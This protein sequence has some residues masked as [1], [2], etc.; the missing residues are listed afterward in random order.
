MDHAARRYPR[1][2]APVSL[3]LGILTVILLAG[4]LGA[5]AL[6]RVAPGFGVDE[7]ML[8]TRLSNDSIEAVARERSQGSHVLS[9]Y[10]DYLRRLAQG[11]LGTSLSLGVPVRDLL[12]ERAGVSFRSAAAGLGV[13]WIASLAVVLLLGVLRRR[14]C[15]ALVSA[16]VGA[17]LA[18]PAAVLAL[19]CF[20]LGGKPEFAIAGIIFPRVFRY[21]WGL[22]RQACAAPHVLTAYA[23]GEAKL[24]IL[25]VHVFTPIL[26]EMMAMAGISVSMAVG[27]T[28]PVEALCD[29][30]GLGQLVWQAALARDLPVIL[31]VTLLIT[32]LTAAANCLADAGRAAREARA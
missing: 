8:D 30:P 20:Y 4:G 19:G 1:W 29:S 13:A 32:A 31:N 22:V 25:W 5:A 2:L 24:R 27:A 21:V 6:V 23:L 12:A 3:R 11:D 18:I 15:E 26:P 28:I 10:G 9:W 14:G 16:A 17:L 7:R